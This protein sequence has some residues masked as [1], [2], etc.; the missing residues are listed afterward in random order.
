MT[1]STDAEKAF[2]IIQYST[3]IKNNISNC[4]QKSFLNVINNIYKKPTVKPYL[5]NH[6]RSRLIRVKNEK[7]K[8]YKAVKKF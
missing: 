2:Y 3:Q 5:W 1:I 6:T 4:K 7:K 8:K